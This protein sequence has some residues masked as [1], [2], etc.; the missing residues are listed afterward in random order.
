MSI[1]YNFE[2]HAKSLLLPQFK[3]SNNINVIVGSLIEPAQET[4]DL[5]NQFPS[6][7]DL[8]TAEGVQLDAI[9]KLLNVEREGGTDDVY[10]K[11]IKARVLINSSTGSGGNFV[12]L[13]RLVLEEIE[14]SVI[15]QYPASVQVII[16][17]P[18]GVVDENLVNDITP[19]GVKGLFFQN[20]YEDKTLFQ[21]ADVS[22]DGL[23]ITG[24]TVVPDVA[25]LPT[26]DVAMANVIYT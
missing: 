14:F 11:R 13:L 1:D 12:S 2:E 8:R 10:R 26:S 16:Y 23:T 21:L 18:Q 20:P 15:E 3:N 6:A 22:D 24:G 4:I 9:G 5:V 25:D 17:S 7:Y 19:I